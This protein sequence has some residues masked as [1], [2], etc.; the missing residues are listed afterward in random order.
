MSKVYTPPTWRQ[1]EKLGEDSWALRY[2]FPVYTITFKDS[3]GVWH[4]QNTVGVGEADGATS[5]FNC[6]ATISDALATEM[7]AASMPGTYV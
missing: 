3:Q 2:G 5:F 1:I 6:P 4:N 7:Q